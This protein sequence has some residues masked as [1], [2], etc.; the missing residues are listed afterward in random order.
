MLTL[1]YGA[2]AEENGSRIY[3]LELDALIRI[4]EEWIRRR[5]NA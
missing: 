4:V 5:P 3:R 1:A 2:L